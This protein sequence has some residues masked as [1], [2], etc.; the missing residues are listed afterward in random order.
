MVK[1]AVFGTRGFP[2]IQ[3]GVEKHCESLYPRIARQQVSIVL[4]RRKPYLTCDSRKAVYSGLTF[5]D[6][7]STRIKGFEAIWHSFLSTVHA[8]LHRADIVH[9]HNAGPALFTPVLRLF[10]KKVV[11]TYHSSNHE[12]EK[13][14]AMERKVLKISETIALKYA[15]E[16]IFVSRFQME[17]YPPRIRQ[18]SIC[19]PNGIEP[20][21]FSD[22][23]E[24]LKAWG[25][26]NRKYI[27]SVGRITPEKGFDVLIKAFA[28]IASPDFKLV[29][30]GGTETETHYY[31]R[32]TQLA[33]DHAE[34]I[35]TGF[36]YGK[37]LQELYTHAQMFVMPSYQEGFPLVLLEA[38]SYRLPL[39]VSDIPATH[40]IRIPSQCY[41]P[42]GDITALRNKI[43]DS[44]QKESLTKQTYDLSAY[45]WD[46]IAAQTLNVYRKCCVR[47]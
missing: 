29:I 15:H 3:G 2:Q 13:W 40:L 25:L 37:A 10:G 28:A 36:V 1:V 12:H 6:L 43:T 4:Y 22:S 27:L 9:I 47:P 19:I 14:N 11:L 35:F 31:R 26:E 30:A 33:A 39:I 32:L 16:I 44:I 18:K 41:F 34:I 21:V 38:M 7:P 20:P 24:R 46:Q 23:S 8:L 42:A 5:T 17:K 45:D